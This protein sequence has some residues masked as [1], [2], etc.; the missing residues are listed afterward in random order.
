MSE[1]TG[2]NVKGLPT[3]RA[4]T[5]KTTG[6]TGGRIVTKGYSQYTAFHGA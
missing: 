6:C 2:A 3:A 5:I 4:G 1:D